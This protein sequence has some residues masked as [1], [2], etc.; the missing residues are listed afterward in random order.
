VN[1]FVENFGPEPLKVTLQDGT[2]VE[3]LMNGY[4]CGRIKT[5]HHGDARAHYTV[6]PEYSEDGGRLVPKVVADALFK[7]V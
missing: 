2:V 6:K 7:E 4:F 5:I 1:H 3:V